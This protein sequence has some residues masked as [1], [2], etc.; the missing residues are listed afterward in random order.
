MSLKNEQSQPNSRPGSAASQRSD[1]YKNLIEERGIADRL[2]KNSQN[3]KAM[4][5][6]TYEIEKEEKSVTGSKHSNSVEVLKRQEVEE[7]S[8]KIEKGGNSAKIDELMT[9]ELMNDDDSE[10]DG[11]PFKKR[12]REKN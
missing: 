9:Y 7:K 4:L 2:R 5:C 11:I 6:N 12:R 10:D 1:N 8:D 3:I